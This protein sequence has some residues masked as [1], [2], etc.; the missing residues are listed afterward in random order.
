MNTAKKFFSTFFLITFI[1]NLASQVTANDQEGSIFSQISSQYLNS[2]SK[3]TLKPE[4]IDLLKNTDPK[5]YKETLKKIIKKKKEE[6]R[7]KKIIFELFDQNQNSKNAYQNPCL[8]NDT[9]WQDLEIFCGEHNPASHLLSKIN[10]TQTHS[11]TAMLAK[12]LVEPTTNITELQKRQNIIKELA[13]NQALFKQL[14]SIVSEYAGI[15]NEVLSFWYEKNFNTLFSSDFYFPPYPLDLLPDS[16]LNVIFPVQIRNNWNQS[17]AKL[18]ILTL[19]NNFTALR[20]II[21]EL[22]STKYYFD[23]ARSHMTELMDSNP[24]INPN[25]GTIQNAINTICPP[26]VQNVL[27]KA[28]NMEQFGWN[29]AQILIAILDAAKTTKNEVQK[30]KILKTA[31]LRLKKAA[32]SIESIKK[33]KKI[34]DSNEALTQNINFLDDLQYLFNGTK[35][36]SAEFDDLLALLQT[37]TFKDPNKISLAFSSGKILATSFLIIRTQDNLIN[38]IQALGQIDAYLSLAKLYKES[39]GKSA[40]YSFAKYINQQTPYVNLKEFWTPFINPDKVITNNIELGKENGARNIIISGPNAGGKSTILKSIIINLLFAQTTGIVPSKELTL[41][42]MVYLDTYLNITDDISSGNSL[43]K[44][45]VLRIKS[46]LEAIKS[47][48]NIGFCFV[49]MDEIFSGTNPAEGEAAGYAIGKYLSKLPHTIALIASHF[50]KITNLEKDTN[51]IFKNYKVT[52]DKIDNKTLSYPF[53]LEEGK[54]NQTIAI[55]ILEAENFD[56]D[57]IND[58]YGI[59]KQKPLQH[60]T[61]NEVEENNNQIPNRA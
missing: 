30:L 35:S 42:P 20:R 8:L 54:T 36:G 4:E 26:S 15:E 5:D 9:L 38:I 61:I 44:S 58:A 47:L 34:I 17:G 13:G 48:H 27:G 43:F 3:P 16:I 50:P 23:H 29:S 7:Y 56:P 12:M 1:L 32:L 59:I 41:T 49:I 28:W 52:V 45:E 11:G 51:G 2:F 6:F 21:N 53:K 18:E 33:I 25:P 60:R 40:T 14:N 37:E 31:Y 46:L 57:I 10:R 24:A 19:F 22:Y 55:N 39:Q